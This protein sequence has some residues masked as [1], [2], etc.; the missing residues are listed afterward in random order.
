MAGTTFANISNHQSLWASLGESTGLANGRP[1]EE[2]QEVGEASR[3]FLEKNHGLIDSDRIPRFP[4][5]KISMKKLEDFDLN[6]IPIFGQA[7]EVHHRAIGVV[8]KWGSP[9]AG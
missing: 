5:S 8:K 7:T 1:A 4:D 2:A 3:D 6:C 9:I